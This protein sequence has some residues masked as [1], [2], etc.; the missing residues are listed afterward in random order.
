MVDGRDAWIGG[1]NIGDEYLGRGEL[2]PWRDTHIRI[3]GPAVTEAQ[4]GFIEDWYWATETI[5]QVA[6][7]VSPNEDGV[8]VYKGVQE[9]GRGSDVYFWMN[10]AWAYPLKL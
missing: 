5:P 9:N 3:E 10:L 1:H 8:P 2:G 7:Q 4:Y 6:W